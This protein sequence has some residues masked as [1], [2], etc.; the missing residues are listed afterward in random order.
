MIVAWVVVL[1]EEARRVELDTSFGKQGLCI[2]AM[3][4]VGLVGGK[5]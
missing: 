3:G 5:H 2:V 1:V 4:M